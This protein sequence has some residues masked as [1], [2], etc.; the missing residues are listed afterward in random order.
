ME[1]Q[2]AKENL[3]PNVTKGKRE[4]MPDITKGK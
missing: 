4:L 1:R 2:D 3:P